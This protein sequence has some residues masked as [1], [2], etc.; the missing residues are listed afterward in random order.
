MTRHLRIAR[1]GREATL[2]A[3]ALALASHADLK[4]I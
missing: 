2:P 4:I 1:H 3:A